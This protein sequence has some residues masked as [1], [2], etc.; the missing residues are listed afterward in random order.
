MCWT[1]FLVAGQV[2]HTDMRLQPQLTKLVELGWA[3]RAR[4]ESQNVPR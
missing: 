1:S 2:L 3:Q 4:A